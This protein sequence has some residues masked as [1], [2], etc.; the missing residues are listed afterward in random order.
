MNIKKTVSRITTFDLMRGFFVLVIII[1]HLQRWPGIFDWFTG[2][3]RLWASAAE[4]F[5]LIS[6]IMIGLIRGRNNIALPFKTVT[7]K[8]WWRALTLY[9]WAIITALLTLVVVAV[10]PGIFYPFP[11]GIDSY[12]S[13]SGVGVVVQTLTLQ[14]TYGWSVFLVLY[15]VFLF[16][17]PAAVWLLRK[18]LWKILILISTLVWVYGFGNDQMLLSWQLLFF[19][20][21][22]VGFYYYDLQKWWQSLRN[23]K[24]Y[25][26]AI[27]GTALA[28]IV[29]SIFTIF[30]WQIV[31]SSWTPISFD[32]FLD[33]RSLIDPYFLRNEL[34]PLR[35]GTALLWFSALYIIFRHY[36]KH[37]LKKLGWLLLRFGQNSLFVYIVQGFVVVAVSALIPQTNNILLNALTII[38]TVL[39][40]WWLTSVAF[41]HKI[42]PR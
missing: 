2:Q 26:A 30:G 36:E 10:W 41:L 38:G 40:V 7:K 18:G 35:L 29:A 4:G 22:V 1:D 6:G 8:I 42:I 31:K 24:I 14:G 27:L 3:G 16:F 13:A 33:Y 25:E 34:A 28:T 39:V 9:A 23:R 5:I 21:T 32:S 20:G 11:P 37:I 19:I 17:A 12:E 15:A